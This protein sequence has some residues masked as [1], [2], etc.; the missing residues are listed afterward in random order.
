MR[1]L[2]VNA[3]TVI[4]A[5]P[6]EL[7]CTMRDSETIATFPGVKRAFEGHPGMRLDIEIPGL[8]IRDRFVLK[9]W[10]PREEVATKVYPFGVEGGRWVTGSGEVAMAT[11]DA[12]HAQIAVQWDIELPRWAWFVPGLSLAGRFALRGATR[13]WLAGI[14]A[15]MES[16]VR[17]ITDPILTPADIGA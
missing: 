6:K 15:S 3:K 4:D 11:I 2:R 5:P 14:K 17:A 7:E 1:S 12:A 8:H 10:R 13:R 9:W 16:A